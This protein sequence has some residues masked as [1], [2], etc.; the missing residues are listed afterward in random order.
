[1]AWLPDHRSFDT[2]RVLVTG[3]HGFIGRH[4]VT[5]LAEAG[6]N[7]ISTIHPLGNAVPDLPGETVTVDL[8]D[9]GQ[10]AEVVN[11]IDVVVHLAARAGGIQ[12]Q[13]EGDP[14]VF[15]TNRRITDN[16][17]AASA[18]S[19]VQSFLPGVLTGD[20]SPGRRTIDRR[21]S[22]TRPDR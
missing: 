8:E 20:V 6:A 7:P 16:L 17:L 10:T 22:P 13:R 4:V 5:A 21:P 12:F 15:A 2:Q 14:H 19:Q 11:G 1:M 18:D 9:R 3:G